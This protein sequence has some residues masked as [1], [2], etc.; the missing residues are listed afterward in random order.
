MALAGQGHV[1][2]ARAIYQK[3]L[4]ADLDPGLTDTLKQEIDRAAAAPPH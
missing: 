1:K 4:A 2:E 3:L